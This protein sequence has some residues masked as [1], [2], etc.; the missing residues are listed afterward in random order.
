MAVTVTRSCLGLW[1]LK[2]G[3]LKVQL[4]DNPLGAI[5]THAEITPDGSHIISAESGNVVMW[6]TEEQKVRFYN[7]QFTNVIKPNQQ[8]MILFIIRFCSEKSK[9]VFVKYY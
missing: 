7:F 8:Y 4:S 2:A 5:I 6:D 1:D 3:K 9:L